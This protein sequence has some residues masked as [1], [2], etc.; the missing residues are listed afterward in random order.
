MKNKIL[1]FFGLILLVFAFVGCKHEED[2]DPVFAGVDDITITKGSTFVALEGVSV[3]DEE[4]GPIDVSA[5]TVDLKNF[6][7]NVEGIYEITYSVTDSYGNTT[8]V[9]RKVTVVYVDTEKPTFY[10]IQDKTIIVGDTSYTNLAGV[11]AIDNVDQDITSSIIATGT[12]DVWTPGEYTVN[13]EVEDAADNK[14]TATRKITV[15][16]GDA[17]FSEINQLGD[18]YTITVGDTAHEHKI[19]GIS[20]GEINEEYADFALIKVVLT[21]SSTVAKEVTI[22]INGATSSSTPITIGTQS[23][24]YVKYFRI[25]APLEN[26]T[27]TLNFAAGAATVTI[28]ESELYFASFEDIEAP[29]VTIEENADVFVPVNIPEAIAKIELLRH[30]Q[31]Q[32]NLDGTLTS[33]LDVDFG[34]ADLSV[35]GEYTVKVYVQDR[36][37][38]RGE[39]ERTLVVAQARDLQFFPDPEF[40]GT[41]T[42]PIKNSTGAGGNTSL[43]IVDGALVLD[44]VVPGGWPSGDSP[45][46]NGLNTDLLTPGFFYMLK[47]DVKADLPRNIII[48]A[49]HELWDTPWIEDFAVGRPKYAITSEY[50]TIY[51]IFYVSKATSEVG[52]KVIKF[53]IQCGAIDYSSN[54][55]NN[56]IY[57]DNMQL[58]KLTNV[59][60]APVIT[61][62]PNIK[63]TYAVGDDLPDLTSFITATDLEDGAITITNAMINDGGLN[64]SVAGEYTVVYTVTDSE[65]KSSTHS[66]TIIV[67]E[68]ADTE[69]PVITIAPEAL[70][71]LQTNQPSQGVDLTEMIATLANYITITDNVEGNIPFSTAMVNWDGLNITSPAAGTYH[72]EIKTKDSSGNDSN[73]VEL[74]LVVKDTEAPKFIMAGPVVL[75]VGDTFN[76]LAGVVINDNLDGLSDVALSNITGLEQFLNANGEVTTAGT[77]QVTYTATDAAGNEGVK[78]VNIEVKATATEFYE[79]AYIDIIDKISWISGDGSGS[80]M[81]DTAAGGIIVDYKPSSNGWAS[82]VH[83]KCNQN[84]NLVSGATFKL[85]IEAKAQLP[86]N[87]AVYFV[88][89]NSEKITGFQNGEVGKQV[90][91]LMDEFYLYE[92][93]FTV[94]NTNVANCT[95]EI[96]LNYDTGL[97]L[98]NAR[99][100]QQI[101]FKQIR[102][103]STDGVLGSD[104]LPETVVF[105]DFESYGSNSEYQENTTDNIVGTRIGTGTFV[106]NKGEL[107]IIDGNRLLKQIFKYEGGSTNGIRI[108]I[109]K[110]DI[111]ANIQYIAVWMKAS[112]I[113]HVSKFQSFRYKSDGGYSEISS[114]VVG[115]INDLV[116]GTFVYIPVSQIDAD[117]IEL[118]LVINVGGSA[119]GILYFDDILFVEDFLIGYGMEVLED[120]EDY[121]AADT[122]VIGYRIAGGNFVQE[123]GTVIGEGNKV[124]K[125]N[126]AYNSSNAT[127]GLKFNLSL[128]DIPLGVKYIAVWMKVDDASLVKAI[129][130]FR[131]AA[132]HTEITSSLI[133]DIALLENGVYVYLPV[134]ALAADTTA[135]SILI[136]VKSDATGELSIDNLLLTKNFLPVVPFGSNPLVYI[137][138]EDRAN[139]ERS[140]L[141]AGVSLTAKLPALLGMIKAID[142]EDGEIAV[143]ADMIDLNGL[144]LENP[145]MGLYNLKVKVTD[146]D[147]NESNELIIP[148]TIVTMLNDF[149]D[150]EDDAEFKADTFL[151]G[152]RINGSDFLPGNGSL[153]VGDNNYLKQNFAANLNGIKFN[154]SKAALV[155]LGAEYVGI[156]VKTSVSDV[157]NQ[158]RIFGYDSTH[159][160]IYNFTGK[161]SDLG[162]GTYIY[163]PISELAEGYTAVSVQIAVNS[164]GSGYIM[165]DNIVIR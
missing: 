4:D 40:N 126:F 67:T 83:L 58:Y 7:P 86:R 71:F 54:E 24:E 146:S 105:N 132:T 51:Y 57:F 133:Y 38:N 92:Y 60:E 127:N 21:A 10:G 118:S 53:E 66:I 110:A 52:S 72:L 63:T 32:D 94:E 151:A 75:Y 77:F 129:K 97:E 120:F 162:N 98:I 46:I 125:Q 148:V 42:D 93:I 144:D 145:E 115:N 124:L 143:T 48:R 8:V 81:T 12:V 84:I 128:S 1:L 138:Q 153:I 13:Y 156:Y 2:K 27:L 161:V 50:Q 101:E 37:G 90:F 95:L 76:P 112:T 136:D 31:A 45:Y 29:E 9:K 39:L 20:G 165:Y 139:L 122:P 89:S 108:K 157:V 74:T 14:Q 55:S 59:N 109:S 64:M 140:T 16:L 23:A 99:K 154:I 22:S 117:T 47:F 87:F 116:N 34:D 70:A 35:A 103:Y 61:Q 111:P 100:A 28:S 88:N 152:F 5:V 56:D 49:G 15:G 150:Y 19:E 135:V 158:I 160:E 163:I 107:V 96:H 82:A 102:L 68:V 131:Y 121:D 79:G 17:F 73:V 106:K 33:V 104:S 11:T 137:S 119:N 6:N 36:A 41:V 85:V 164:G 155:A 149:E 142:A 30:V 78:T 18:E 141:E 25:A 159:H 69:G 134:S 114:S 65:G 147:G 91:G 44:V 43:S 113:E 26:A 3:T 80:T 130:A 123:N 62:T